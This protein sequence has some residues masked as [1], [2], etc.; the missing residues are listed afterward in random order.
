M[1]ALR[2]T[3]AITDSIQYRLRAAGALLGVS[4]NTL[5][6]YSDTSGL[7][8][9]RAS[10]INPDSPAVRVF[11]IATLFK[12]AAWRRA[13]GLSKALGGAGPLTIAVDVIKGGTGKSTTTVELGLHLALMGMRVLLIDLDPQ[14]NLTQMMGYEADLTLQEAPEYKL[15]SA[16][17]VTGTFA[18]VMIPFI[19]RQRGTLRLREPDS[20][21][22]I[23]RPFG[24]AGPALIPA[25]TFI[26]D[27]EQAIGSAK[28]HRE[29]F[30]R[31]MIEASLAGQV[32]GLDVKQFDV[33]LFDCPPSISFCSTNALA[34][35]D[36]VVSPIKLDSF[37]VKGLT[38][39]MSE[40]QGLDSTYHIRPELI[41]LPTHYAPNLARIGRMQSQLTIYKQYLAPSA[42]SASEEFPKS[43]DAYLPLSLQKPT[44]NAA[45]EYRVFSEYVLSR[46]HKI[47]QERSKCFNPRPD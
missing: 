36:I 32:P 4:D 45:K 19:E 30:F 15:T 24:D 39:L 16:A 21:D 43:L 23:K 12:M 22:F 47:V 26:G 31:Q 37:S 38:K 5:R 18:S 8:I 40:L 17:I 6:G 14:A 41:I 42:I 27:L 1:S 3:Y 20:V 28:G 29:L 25:D 9:R 44:V 10:E 35:A 2:D 33:I 11:D 7:E 34:A 46:P 13:Q